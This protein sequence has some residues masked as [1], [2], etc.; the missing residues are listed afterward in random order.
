MWSFKSYFA[1]FH[2]KFFPKN[3]IILQIN[4]LFDLN[5]CYFTNI[6]V[7][8]HNLILRFFT[9]GRLLWLFRNWYVRTEYQQ[10]LCKKDLRSF[11]FEIPKMSQKSSPKFFGCFCLF[12]GLRWFLWSIFIRWW[13]FFSNSWPNSP[14]RAIQKFILGWFFGIVGKIIPKTIPNCIFNWIY[15]L[16]FA[17]C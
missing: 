5:F 17:I 1:W 4:D 15:E 12:L 2:A 8:L 14:F 16:I 6:I 3:I 9:F 7:T 11:T 10:K 13:T